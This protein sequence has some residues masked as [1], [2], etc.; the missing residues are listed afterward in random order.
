MATAMPASASQVDDYTNA[1]HRA[2]TLVQF[3]ERGDTPS[4]GQALQALATAPGPDQPEIL[5]DLGTDPPNLTDAEQRLQ[6][7]YTALQARVDTPDPGRAQQQLNSVLSM[8]RYVGLASGP[9][10][11]DR[12]VIAVVDT[13][14]R[15]FRW[16]G[17]G[18]FHPNVPL[19]IWLGLATLIILG[20][21]VWPIRGTLS[22]GGREA[23]PRAR[24]MAVRPSFDFFAEADRLAA[25]GDFLGAI[26]ALAGG[27]TV[28]SSG[29]RAWDRSPFTVRELFAR[30][31]DPEVL[32]QLLRSFE[33]A[34][35]GHRAP[36]QPMYAQAV[37]A[38]QRY[39]RTAA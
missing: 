7:L 2:L 1:I 26:Q 11:L 13:L 29:E 36:D 20:I 37:E 34:S 10:L 12:I 32:R 15:F 17:L 6:A 19:W 9:S 18:N 4:V 3:A 8:P 22:R 24:P 23:V 21:I 30:T 27:V 38:A 14:G 39:R 33:E 28:S 25:A 16:L 35:Y 31:K 5:H